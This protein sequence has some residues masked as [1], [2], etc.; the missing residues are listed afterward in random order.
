MR[1]FIGREPGPDMTSAI[2]LPPGVSGVRRFL[3]RFAMAEIP[4]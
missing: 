3:F 2:F 4:Q 1:I